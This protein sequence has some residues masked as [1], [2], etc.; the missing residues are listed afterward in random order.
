MID[1]TGVEVT[2]Y[3]RS[4]AFYDAAFAAIGVFKQGMALRIKLNPAHIEEPALGIAAH[5]MLDLDDVGTPVSKN[6]ASR[7]HESELRHF[8]NA[9]AFHHLCHRFPNWPPGIRTAPH[10]PRMQA[11]QAQTLN[12]GTKSLSRARCTLTRNAPAISA[13]PGVVRC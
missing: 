4:K 5:R 2:D 11:G 7:R 6:A 3:A 10:S 9:Y 8:Q 13:N 12:G 1:H